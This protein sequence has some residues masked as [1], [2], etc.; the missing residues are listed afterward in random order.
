MFKKKNI[1]YQECPSKE[2]CLLKNPPFSKGDLLCAFFATAYR[3]TTIPT[4]CM[5]SFA[6]E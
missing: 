4:A 3:I 2:F 6:N 1:E 5:M